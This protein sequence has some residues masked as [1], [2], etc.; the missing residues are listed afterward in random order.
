[1]NVMR[2]W[3]RLVG[4]LVAVAVC[5][6]CAVSEKGRSLETNA[7]TIIALLQD[8]ASGPATTSHEIRHTIP[9]TVNEPRL[10]PVIKFIPTL[11]TDR[12][13]A[14]EQ[15]VMMG[16]VL[17]EGGFEIR[18]STRERELIRGSYRGRRFFGPFA[19][20]SELREIEIVYTPGVGLSW[21][22]NGYFASLK[23]SD[24]PEQLAIYKR[25]YKAYGD[26][27]FASVILP[28][29]ESSVL[30]QTPAMDSRATA[31]ALEMSG[32]RY[33]S[34]LGGSIEMNFE[35]AEDYEIEFSEA[36]E[37]D[38]WFSWDVQDLKLDIFV[39]PAASGFN[40]TNI[41]FGP[42]VVMT[43]L[44]A[45]GVTMYMHIC[46]QPSATGC[47]SWQTRL[48]TSSEA[49][50][51]QTVLESIL[52]GEEILISKGM[53]TE[54]TLPPNRGVSCNAARFAYAWMHVKQRTEAPLTHLVTDVL[55]SEDEGIL[56]TQ[57]GTPII[58]SYVGILDVN[59]M[60]T[61]SEM[62]NTR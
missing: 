44:E 54:C 2:F 52:A 46:L 23:G 25:Y 7:G 19:T 41:W 13:E 47:Q 24:A 20:G 61:G 6:S 14:P 33:S 57:L 18:P 42:T 39:K 35:L 32:I 30:N 28:G 29:L 45:N 16:M 9:G 27:S 59:L 4:L 3:R 10:P 15:G 50:E 56:L 62:T 8:E 11:E 31:V 60:T 49:D 34:V 1:M 53:N 26:D 37:N 12:T 48:A 51:H 5:G 38:D 22:H 21:Y 40:P 55:I 58:V 36:S 43:S 17:P